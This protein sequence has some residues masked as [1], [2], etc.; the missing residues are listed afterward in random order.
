MKLNKLIALGLIA[1]STF[2]FGQET[3]D[4]ETKKRKFSY[5][6]FFGLGN[7]TLEHNKLG[8]LNCD[9]IEF[10]FNVAYGDEK[11]RIASGIEFLGSNAGFFD[12]TKQSTLKNNYLQIPLKLITRLSID[13]E[14]KLILV[15]G[16]GTYVNFLLDSSIYSNGD[17]VNTKSGGVN[18]G[19]IFALGLEYKLAPNTSIGI[20]SD[21][22]SEFSAIKKNGYEQ[23]QT[24]IIAFSAGF[25]Q[26]F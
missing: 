24:G 22:L 8:T 7:S 20:N 11:F 14:E 25:T 21:A 15:T 18:M 26:K 17:K 12:G 4:Q 13:K 23:K 19:I 6:A 10:R 1:T 3:N 9:V 16:I 2:C 5:G